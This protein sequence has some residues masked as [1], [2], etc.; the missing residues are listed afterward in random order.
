MW[1]VVG[2]LT[3]GALS[4]SVSHST[5]SPLRGRISVLS[6]GQATATCCLSYTHHMCVL[7][8]QA[9][10]VAGGIAGRACFIRCAGLCHR[11][12]QPSA[13]FRCTVSLQPSIIDDSHSVLASRQ[14]K[15]RLQRCFTV[16]AAC[17]QL[18]CACQA[19]VAMLTE[20]S[21]SGSRQDLNQLSQQH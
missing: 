8:L 21:R 13:T 4:L 9:V 12:Q 16:P 7:L 1:K 15:K 19:C 5:S 6:A 14:R 10:H 3:A 2:V 11:S 20:R 17:R 18:W